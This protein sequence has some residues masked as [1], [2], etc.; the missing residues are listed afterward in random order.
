MRKVNGGDI[1]LACSFS[2]VRVDRHAPTAYVYGMTTSQLPTALRDAVASFT[3]VLELS[4]PRAWIRF[5][6]HRVTPTDA[7]LLVDGRVFERSVP[8]SD[9]AVGG[10]DSE[11][12][13]FEAGIDNRLDER[14]D[15]PEFGPFFALANG[16]KID[17][18]L[19]RAGWEPMGDWKRKEY[20]LVSYRGDSPDDGDAVSYPVFESTVHLTWDGLRSSAFDLLGVRRL[21]AAGFHV[22]CPAQPEAV[23][24]AAETGA[25]D[26]ADAGWLWVD[27]FGGYADL[28]RRYWA[29][30]EVSAPV[31]AEGCAL[32]ST[33]AETFDGIDE[34]ESEHLHA[35]LAELAERGWAVTGLLDDGEVLGIC[36]WAEPGHTRNIGRLEE[37]GGVDYAEGRPA[38]GVDDFA[39][40]DNLGRPD[41]VPATPKTCAVRAAEL[42]KY[43]IA[44]VRAHRDADRFRIFT[45]DVDGGVDALTSLVETTLDDVRNPRPW[46]RRALG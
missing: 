6:P 21:M 38:G 31:D 33:L 28:V 42:E 37:L 16:D 8:L 32:E 18:E 11:F 34:E 39:W 12:R 43:G 7:P 17:A 20:Q 24:K 35:M 27:D 30:A 26:D 5:S 46:I 15:D 3:A 19:R 44:A 25:F 29:D 45:R 9:D 4:G 10:L 22:D 2:G 23:R 40:E 13:E 14:L 41:W 1:A 36:G